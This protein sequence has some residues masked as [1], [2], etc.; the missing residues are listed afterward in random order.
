MAGALLTSVVADTILAG[1]RLSEAN[2]PVASLIPALLIAIE[3]A[4]LGAL[5]SQIRTT[6]RRTS[7]ASALL[8]G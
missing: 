3:I 8:L 7:F 1:L 4:L 6:M 2:F 5:A